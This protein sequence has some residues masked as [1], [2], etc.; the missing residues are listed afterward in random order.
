[1]DNGSDTPEFIQNENND[2]GNTII[3]QNKKRKRKSSKHNNKI[4]AKRRK[5]GK[6]KFE[7]KFFCNVCKI[8]GFAYKVL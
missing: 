4:K 2:N 6:R 8:R 7:K 5:I 3:K 1:M